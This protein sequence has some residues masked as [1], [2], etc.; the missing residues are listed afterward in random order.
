MT[1]SDKLKVGSIIRQVHF[2]KDTTNMVVTRITKQCIFFEKGNSG[3]YQMDDV[4]MMKKN[5][6][7]KRVEYGHLK[8]IK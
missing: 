8:Q 2:K 7:N 1:E 3:N 6:Y 5:H 4:L